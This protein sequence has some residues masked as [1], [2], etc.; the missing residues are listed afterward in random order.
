MGLDEEFYRQL[1]AE[2]LVKKFIDGYPR[3][4]WIKTR[5]RNDVLDCDVYCLAAAYKA[6]IVRIDFE[7]LESNLSV[8]SEKVTVKKQKR[9]QKR[10]PQQQQG[11][12]QRPSW[13]N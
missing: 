2:K 12:Y 7:K 10:K 13:M 9:R 5:E 6:G 4:R 3:Y 11:G 1:T 8:L